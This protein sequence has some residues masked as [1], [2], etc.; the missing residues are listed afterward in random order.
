[1]QLTGRGQEGSKRGYIGGTAG[2]NLRNQ[3]ETNGLKRIRNPLL[4]PL[5]YRGEIY[6]AQFEMIRFILTRSA[7]EGMTYGLA[8]DS[9]LGMVQFTGVLGDNVAFRSAKV[10]LLSRSERRL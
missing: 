1:M 8:C 4:Y 6:F 7:S 5:S 9:G 2:R 3:P 10:A